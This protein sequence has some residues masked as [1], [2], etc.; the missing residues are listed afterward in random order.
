MKRRKLE[1]THRPTDIVTQTEWWTQGLLFFFAANK[2]QTQKGQREGFVTTSQ[3]VCQ[4]VFLYTNQCEKSFSYFTN[5][6]KVE[7]RINST[8][9]AWWLRN[10]FY[11]TRNRDVLNLLPCFWDLLVYISFYI[12]QTQECYTMFTKNLQYILLYFT[13]WIQNT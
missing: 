4:F 13:K 12:L 1:Q 2:I 5:F 9:K 10:F 11:P 7:G 3:R 6:G 8:L